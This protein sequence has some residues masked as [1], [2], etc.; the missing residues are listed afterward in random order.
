MALTFPSSPTNGQIYTD[1]VTGNRYIYDSSKGLWKYSSNNVGMTVSTVAPS[2]VAAGAMWFNTNI[3][4]TFVYYDD[5]DS[6]QWVETVPAGTVDTNTIAGYVNPVFASMNAAY[7]TTNA[8]FGVANAAYNAANN[9][10]LSAPFN[11]ANAAYGKANT[12]LQ[13]TS[14][15]FS[16]NLTI[17]GNLDLSLGT[18][19][20]KLPAGNTAQRPANTAGYFRHNTER[21]AIEFNDGNGWQVVKSLVNTTG[22]VI[23][24]TPTYRLHAFLGSG[25]FY[26]DSTVT[27]DI[28]VVG[29]GGAGGGSYGDQDTGKG[30]GGAGG[31]VYKQGHS[32]TAGS[33]TIL[34]GAGGPGCM[35]GFNSNGGAGAKGDDSSAFSVTANGGGGGGCSDNQA[36]PTSG[37]RSEEHTS[38]LQSH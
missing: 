18:S 17:S 27:A 20:I 21:K 7:A 9:V 14:V 38:E 37:G 16:G 28:L 4:R 36:A 6:K 2:N 15:T 30:G 26:T 32:I 3:G 19:A 1:T 13:N 24:E 10:N 12:S 33:Y 23:V 25:T 22:G 29:G 34:V 5:G 31:V 8:G 35:R 11:T